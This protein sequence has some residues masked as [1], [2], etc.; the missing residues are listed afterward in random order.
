MPDPQM[1]ESGYDRNRLDRYWTSPWLTEELLKHSLEYVLS[2]VW[3]PACGRGDISGVLGKAGFK[4]LNSDIDISEFNAPGQV[5]EEIDFLTG[6]PLFDARSIITNPPYNTLA[7]KFV[8]RALK[9]MDELD[10]QYTAMLMRSEFKSGKT[11]ADMFGDC[12]HYAGEL[13]LTTRPRWDLDDPDRPEDA[14]PRHNYS[15][16]IWINNWR[17]ENDPMQAFSYMPKGFKP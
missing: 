5:A 13:V 11:R 10:V 4:V 16:F 15:W 7:P 1:Y 8:R 6:V 3:E 12:P 9:M 2:P 14:A 17:E